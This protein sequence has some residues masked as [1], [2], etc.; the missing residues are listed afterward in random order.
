MPSK[1]RYTYDYPRP[2]LTVDTAVFTTVEGRLHLLVIERAADPF[3]GCW[4]LPGGFVEEGEAPAAAAAR[5]LEEETEVRLSAPPAPL[6]VYYAKGRDP[7]GWTVS[8]AHIAVV[9]ADRHRPSGGDDAAAATWLPIEELAGRLAFDHAEIVAD[10]RARLLADV[11]SGRVGGE[12]LP[13]SAKR[14][15]VACML[16]AVG[17]SLSPEAWRA[18]SRRAR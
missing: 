12:L 15:H 18:R 4:A 6:G 3:A 9:R 2:A 17:S 16:E 11:E 5:E 10:A 13:D 14:A 7:R 8:L 1:P